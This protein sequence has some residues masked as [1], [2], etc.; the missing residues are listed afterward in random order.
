MQRRR[1]NAQFA[2]VG[3]LTVLS[4]PAVPGPLDGGGGGE[5]SL[6]FVWIETEGE[7]VRLSSSSRG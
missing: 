3:G 4:A 5:V 2:K 1:A 6:S 7:R